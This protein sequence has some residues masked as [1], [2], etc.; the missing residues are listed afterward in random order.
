MLFSVYP[1][2]ADMVCP[3]LYNYYKA[4]IRFFQTNN[5]RRAWCFTNYVIIIIKKKRVNKKDN[6]A[7]MAGQT[8]GNKKGRNE[9]NMNPASVM[10]IMGMKN[11]FNRRHPKFAAFMKAVMAK[12]V[13]EGSVI[14]ITVRNPGSPMRMRY[15]EN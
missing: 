10:K 8:S 4:Q 14:E 2:S 12:G 5:K 15:P 9:R 13:Q 1:R 6:F 7:G 3:L 11:E